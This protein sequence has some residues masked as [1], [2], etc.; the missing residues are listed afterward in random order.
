MDENKEFFFNEHVDDFHCRITKDGKLF[1]SYRKQ[2]WVERDWYKSE[3]TNKP[4][5]PKKRRSVVS[6]LKM[7][8]RDGDYDDLKVKIVKAVG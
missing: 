4:W 6:L 5:F 3:G 7:S 8:I 2:P 1:L